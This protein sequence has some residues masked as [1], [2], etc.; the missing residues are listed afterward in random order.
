MKLRFK[1]TL[2]FVLMTS[3]ALIV[4]SSFGFIH[5]KKQIIKNIDSEMYTTVNGISNQF[6]EWL[7]GKTKVVQATNNIL[8]NSV[9]DGVIS[10]DYLQ[11]YKDDPDITDM[12]FGFEENGIFLDGGDWIPPEGYDCR[13]RAWYKEAL[14]ADAVIFTNPYID[15]ITGKYVVSAAVPSK[16]TDDNIKGVVGGDILLSKLQEKVNE[17]NIKDLFDPQYLL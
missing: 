10:K 11:A 3:I 1:L 17:V 9:K 8:Q 16:Y 13:G 7:I 6:D 14:A 2:S 12:Y 4:V 5:M 15:I